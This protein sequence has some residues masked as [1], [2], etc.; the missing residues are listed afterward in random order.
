[1]T[2]PSLEL[3][4]YKVCFSDNCK[5]INNIDS[6]IV[7]RCHLFVPLMF[8]SDSERFIVHDKGP[9]KSH[10]DKQGGEGVHEISM[11]LN[12]S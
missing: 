6:K 3:V 8:L 5:F 2:H 12:K 1:M 4:L 9:F 10:V 7:S 11:L